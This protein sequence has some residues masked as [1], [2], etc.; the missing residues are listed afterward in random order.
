VG[1][2]RRSPAALP[3]G[4]TQYPLYRMLAASQG[5]SRRVRKIS[6]P[7]GFHLLTV[8]SVASRYTYWAIPAYMEAVEYPQMSVSTQ[9]TARCHSNNR[10][11]NFHSSEKLKYGDL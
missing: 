9:Q 2:Q 7:P 6:P 8:Q 11:A 10:T 3:P 5:W 4:N 1:G